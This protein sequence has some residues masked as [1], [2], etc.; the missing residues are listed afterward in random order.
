MW[1]PCRRACQNILFYVI[2]VCCS[3]S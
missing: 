2:C 1:L 3:K